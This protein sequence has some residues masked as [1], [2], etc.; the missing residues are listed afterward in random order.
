MRSKEMSVETQPSCTATVAVIQRAL[1]AEDEREEIKG[2]DYLAKSFLPPEFARELLNDSE[3]RSSLAMPPTYGF[4]TARTAYFDQIFRKS[5]SEGVAQ[6]VLFGAGY[7]S[8]AYRY[9]Q[10]IRNTRIFEIDIH[11]TQQ[12]KLAMLKEAQ[13]DIP[14]KVSF[15]PVDFHSDNLKDTLVNA[16]FDR[17]LRTLF[18]W[19]GV[20]YYLSEEA[21]DR[22]LRFV[23]AYSPIGSTICFDYLTERAEWENEDEPFRFWIE[24]EKI[25]AFLSYRGLTIIEHIEPKEIERRY[26]TLR[27][28]SLAEET[29]SQVSFVR[30]VVS[31]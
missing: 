30:A 12:N 15:I 8:R 7:D 14:P 31:A 20:S 11:T 19:E 16:G 13:I 23:H 9:R 1:A 5:L 3:F 2:A 4:I 6:I 26:L 18:I 10:F 28:G 29:W 25:E 24:P 17:I 22:I 21:V 27:N